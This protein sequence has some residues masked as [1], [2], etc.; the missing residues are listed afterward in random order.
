MLTTVGAGTREDVVRRYT[1]ATSCLMLMNI[2]RGKGFEIP[3]GRGQ[4]GQ[5]QG[6]VR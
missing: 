4:D 1:R 6:Y 5:S 3:L 2:A